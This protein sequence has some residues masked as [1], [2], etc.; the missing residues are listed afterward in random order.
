[1]KQIFFLHCRLTFFKPIHIDYHY[2]FDLSISVISNNYQD[3][4]TLKPLGGPIFDLISP[5]YLKSL[6]YGSLSMNMEMTTALIIRRKL[7]FVLLIHLSF[8]SKSV[9]LTHHLPSCFY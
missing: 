7:K 5:Y 8:S 6:D 3:M 2:H 9:L 4:T 1:M